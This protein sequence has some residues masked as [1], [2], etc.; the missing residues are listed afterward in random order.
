MSRE[1]W[2]SLAWFSLGSALAHASH[3][4]WIQ[5]AVGVIGA[6]LILC[7]DRVPRQSDGKE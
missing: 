7:A 5:V 2:R 6:V 1:F 4:D 3:G